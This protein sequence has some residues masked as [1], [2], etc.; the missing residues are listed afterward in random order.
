MLPVRRIVEVV[1][2]GAKV[3]VFETPAS[4]AVTPPRSAQR[5]EGDALAWTEADAMHNTRCPACVSAR[6]CVQRIEARANGSLFI[7]HEHTP[8]RP[9]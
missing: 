4:G 9:N 5:A 1:R 6:P 2:T 3:T 7:E 8:P